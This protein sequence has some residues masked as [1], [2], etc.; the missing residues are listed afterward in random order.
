MAI[1]DA[2]LDWDMECLV[3][4]WDIS[5]ILRTIT[6]VMTIYDFSYLYR[7]QRLE[8]DVNDMIMRAT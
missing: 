5:S 7:T 2:S 1:V 3:G 8:S 4:L 6:S